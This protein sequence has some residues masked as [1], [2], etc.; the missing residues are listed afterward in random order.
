MVYASIVGGLVL[1]GT[2]MNLFAIP[3]PLWFSI[4]AVLA[5]IATIFITG[6]LGSSLVP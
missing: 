4:T 5:V 6:R 2:I 1:L 3:H